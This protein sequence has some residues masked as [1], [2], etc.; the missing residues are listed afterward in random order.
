MIL[1]SVEIFNFRSIKHLVLNDLPEHGLVMI[2]GPNEHGKSTVMEAVAMALEKRHNS[3]ARD[4]LAVKPIGF[5][6]KPQVNLHMSLGEYEFTISKRWGGGA[7]HE[8]NVVKPAHAR[9]AYTGA[10]A[11]DA[12]EQ[13]LAE[14]L[15]SQLRNL[16]F[17]RQGEL[18]PAQNVAGIP[19]LA[20]V[21]ATRTANADA[22]A[23]TGMAA[24]DYAGALSENT[25]LEQRVEA[26]YA[27]FYSKTAKE[28]GELKAVNAEVEKAQA[29]L[30][31]AE[32]AYKA[33]ESSV[34]AIA[35]YQEQLQHAQEKLPQ[36]QRELEQAKLEVAKA[37]QIQRNVESAAVRLEQANNAAVQAEEAVQARAKRH[38]EIEQ[39]QTAHAATLEQLEH[40]AAA[41]D[42]EEQREVKAKARVKELREQDRELAK[43]AQELRSLRAR[44]EA[45]SKLEVLQQQ[46]RRIKE[47]N[48]E[49]ETLGRVPKVQQAS[50]DEVEAAY[51]ALEV[52]RELASVAA[53]RVSFEPLDAPVDIVFDGA[54][55]TI[56]APVEHAVASKVSFEHAGL[57]ATFHAGQD[58][59]ALSERVT[60]AEAILAELLEQSGCKDLTELRQAREAWQD[61]QSR[62]E[63]LR[64]ERANL[65]GNTT[66]AELAASLEA[67]TEELATPVLESE[68]EQ[69]D[70]AAIATQLSELDAA[71]VEVQEQV[72]GVDND[73]AQAESHQARTKLVEVNTEARLGEQR[74][75]ELR[76]RLE[77]EESKTSTV[78]L[79]AALTKAV[80]EKQEA[81]SELAQQQ[82][83]AEEAN[84]EQVASVFEGLQ[85]EVQNFQQRITEAK[86]RIDAEQ[87]HISA[88]QG[89][90]ETL[91][92]AKG[93][94]EQVV[95]RQRSIQRQA[96]AVSL[97]RERLGFHRDEMRRKYTEPYLLQLTSLAKVLYGN[98]VDFEVNEKL[99]IV[100]R[101][102]DGTTVPLAQLS[103]GAQEQLAL[104][105]RFAIAQ[106]TSDTQVPIFVDDALG[107]T[108]PHRIRQLAGL[109]KKVAGD[110]QVFL[111]TC[112]EERYASFDAQY[113][114]D[115]ESTVQRFG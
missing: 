11:D 46:L 115:M 68:F 6:E 92:Q 18:G 10:E 44:R 80:A 14:H 100:A 48:A 55:T 53:A 59:S 63:S 21:L 106:L 95:Q 56:D 2:H 107:A 113:K 24:A 105:N 26:E 12:L 30:Q 47:I 27:R 35:R 4:V 17:V 29:N 31:A 9:R 99:E 87:R 34:D 94:L 82:A 66:E 45:E 43:R 50:V 71:R 74:L 1:H 5:D 73:T 39:L 49:L 72:A 76:A 101:S 33:V 78:L 86:A 42:E 89:A 3:K 41:A 15:D 108:D 19:S 70:D 22:A 65:L 102:L 23:E 114:V 62:S 28:A 79:Q 69:L 40:A 61:A 110:T 8:L 57:R 54:A 67:L 16:L 36:S 103:G 58:T 85:V 75:S 111:L 81:T 84:L 96:E 13:I 32:G 97:L 60:E 37:E 77:Q 7:K 112:A 25:S 98:S 91:E 38:S 20:Q 52:A 109:F 88:G 83:Q 104:L 90:A 51:R 93:A 64:R